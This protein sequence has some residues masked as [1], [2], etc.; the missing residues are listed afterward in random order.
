MLGTISNENT[1]PEEEEPNKSLG[2]GRRGGTKSRDTKFKSPE[3]GREDKRHRKK[4]KVNF[5]EKGW[6]VHIKA[7]ILL[8]MYTYIHEY[9]FEYMLFIFI[10]A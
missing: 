9:I 4:K 8:I 7:L 5:E 2:E 1:D 3:G 6:G 10:S